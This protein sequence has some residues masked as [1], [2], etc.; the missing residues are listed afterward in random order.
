MTDQEWIAK[1]DAYGADSAGVRERFMEDMELYESCLYTF[2]EDPNFP[3]LKQ[4]LDAG[5]YEKAFSA[6]HALKGVSANLGLTPLYQAV[7]ELVEALRAQHH[8][9]LTAQYERALACY[10]RAIAML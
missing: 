7:C 2:A 8:E 4:A 5:D 10:Q 9:D 3:A 1:L 6:A